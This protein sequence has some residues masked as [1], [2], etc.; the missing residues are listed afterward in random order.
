MHFSCRLGVEVEEWV[1]EMHARRDVKT[2]SVKQN[3]SPVIPVAH[4]SVPI[5]GPPQAVRTVRACA[6]AR[7]Q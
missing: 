2:C 3:R 7:T 4:A 5:N 1:W 6:L